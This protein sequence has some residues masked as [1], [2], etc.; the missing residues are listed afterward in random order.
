MKRVNS[1][2][3]V[4]CVWQTLNKKI[5]KTPTTWKLLC[6][7]WGSDWWLQWLSVALYGPEWGPSGFSNGISTDWFLFQSYL[8]YF[9]TFMYDYF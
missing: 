9:P 3:A 8:L 5:K 6:G 7:A 1:A 4:A 2:A